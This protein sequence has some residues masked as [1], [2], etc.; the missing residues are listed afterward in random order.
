MF[1]QT[2]NDNTLSLKAWPE[3]SKSGASFVF[4]SAQNSVALHTH[5]DLS[6]RGIIAAAVFVRT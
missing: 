2:S 1:L 5:G 3:N 6:S 4:T